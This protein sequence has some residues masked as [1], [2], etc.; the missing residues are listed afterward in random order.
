MKLWVDD[1]RCP[2]SDE[3]LHAVSVDQ[4]KLAIQIYLENEDGDLLID[5]DHDAGQCAHS[6]DEAWISSGQYGF[7][8]HVQHA[9][10]CGDF[11]HAACR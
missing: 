8:Y 10:R 1:I 9:C 6:H 3:W 7:L 2:P 11:R 5:M 4:A